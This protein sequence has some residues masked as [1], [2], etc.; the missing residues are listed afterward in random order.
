MF[1]SQKCDNACWNTPLQMTSEP[2][3]KMANDVTDAVELFVLTAF[4]FQF[5]VRTMAR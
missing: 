5:I 3:V 4:K 1:E 2:D